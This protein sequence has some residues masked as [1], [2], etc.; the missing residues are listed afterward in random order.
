MS[1]PNWPA[2]GY[3]GSAIHPNAPINEVIDQFNK[4]YGCG[5]DIG[6]I[7]DLSTQGG[8]AAYSRVSMS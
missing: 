8:L 7:Y 6:H 5:M 4:I 3:A 2:N 1:D